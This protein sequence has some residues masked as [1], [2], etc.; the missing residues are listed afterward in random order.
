[1]ISLLEVAER[2]QK[3]PKMEVGKWERA[4]FRKIGELTQRHQIRCP[5]DGSFFNFDDA[6]A[7]RAYQA[8]VDFLVEMGVY[9]VSTSR[10]VQFT[11]EEVLEAVRMI[12]HQ[13]IIGQG[14]DARVVSQKKVEGT[15]PLGHWPGLHAPMSEELAPLAV[16]D[17]AMIPSADY[18]HG[19][20]FM[21][22]D[23]KEIKGLAMEAYAAR[24]QVAWMREG[25][26]KA[27]RPGMAIA[28]YPL[29][30]RA[31][32]LMAP[33]DADNGLRPTDGVLL[34]MLPDVKMEQDLLTGAIVLCQDYG[35]FNQCSSG[36]LVGGFCGGVEGAVVEAIAKA[37]AGRMVYRG[38]PITTGLEHVLETNTKVITHRAEVAWGTSVIHQALNYNTN[39]ICNGPR[40]GGK[41]AIGT[42]DHLIE[43]AIGAI[44]STIDGGNMGITRQS[45]PRLNRAQTPLEGLWQW[46]VSQ[47][48][49]RS[50]LKRPEADKLVRSLAASIEGRPVEES[51]DVREIYDWENNRPKAAYQETYLRTK[52]IL[53]RQGLDFA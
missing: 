16:R 32:A 5:N 23:G 27:G 49:I 10:I 14:R 30:M 22:V 19:F 37:I 40:G 39:T 42:E 53:S 4:L 8:G 51:K 2:T 15:E 48:T 3:G 38:A 12:P 35:C 13:I 45:P 24:R 34:A 9:D 43:T 47:A 31:G 11:R 44:R 18:L 7:N 26:R 1:M 21:V 29:T 20:N 46:E 50:G 28:L 36:T 17:W 25:V 52:E 33:M 6:L 41:A